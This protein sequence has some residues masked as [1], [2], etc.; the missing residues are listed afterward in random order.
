MYDCCKSSSGIGL[1]HSKQ[2]IPSLSTYQDTSFAVHML[3]AATLACSMQS[4]TVSN[5]AIV[6]NG[7]GDT[8]TQAPCRRQRLLHRLSRLGAL[9]HCLA[10]TPLTWRSNSN[11]RRLSSHQPDR[12]L[13]THIPALSRPTLITQSPV[14]P[15]ILLPLLH[16][17]LLFHLQP[18]HRPQRPRR[19]PLQHQLMPLLLMQSTRR[20]MRAGTISTTHRTQHIWRNT[21]TQ[22][23]LSHIHNIH[24]QPL[25]PTRSRMALQPISSHQ[26]QYNHNQQPISHSMATRIHL[27]ASKHS[28]HSHTHWRSSFH[29]PPPINSPR[30]LHTLR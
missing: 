11:T 4:Q 26:L 3:S 22:P 21:R 19:V 17:L 2:Y 13:L 27:P 24:H 28:S 5:A 20:T 14:L 12:Q 29:P 6:A 9:L 23:Y 10:T 25:Q 15:P 7:P 30:P 18:L 1:I 8:G 16:P